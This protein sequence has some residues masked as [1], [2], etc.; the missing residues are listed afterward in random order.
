M[1]STMEERLQTPPS[2]WEEEKALKSPRTKNGN[3]VTPD[4]PYLGIRGLLESGGGVRTP[5]PDLRFR[6]LLKSAT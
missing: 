5:P 4:E 1:T 3:G 2:T 6:N